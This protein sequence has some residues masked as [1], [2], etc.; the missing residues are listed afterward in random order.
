MQKVGK[1]LHFAATLMVAVGTFIS[2]FWILSVNS[3]MQTPVGHAINADGQFVPARGWFEIIFNPSFPYRLVHTVIAAYL[4]TALCVGAVGAWHLLKDSQQAHA[5]KMFS[6]ALWMAALVA[7][8]QVFVGDQH[9]LNTLEHQP[10][11]VMAMEGHF[12]SHPEGAPLILFG[13]PNDEEQRMEHAIEIPKLGS[14]ILKHDLDAPLAGLDTI[15]PENRP[16]V[17]MVFWS[18]RVMVGLGTLMLL[19]G[20][21]SL[22]ARAAG[23]LY[24]WRWLARFA[25]LM[26]PS[27]FIAVIA[28]WI[29]TEVGRQPYTIYGLLRTADSVSP[30]AAPAVATSLI[31]FVIVYFAVF[32]MGSWY[33]LKL[34]SRAPQPHEPDPPQAPAHAAGITSA[35]AFTT[36]GKEAS[37][38]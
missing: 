7:P 3:W 6:M 37:H 36:P 4:T 20:V 14:L 19:L 10:A 30:L 11:K 28:G 35:S 16:P 1:R 29:T 21:C 24:D 9:G 2:A 34:M 27:G 32:G 17:E 18:F 23:K 26:G 31:A 15:A 13:I 25:L 5:R 38:G 22:I 8:V 33:L 12:Q